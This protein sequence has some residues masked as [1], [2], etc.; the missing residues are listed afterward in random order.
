MVR[1]SLR[2]L[3]Q[4]SCLYRQRELFHQRRRTSNAHPQG[5]AC[6]GPTLFRL[7]KIGP[8]NAE[9]RF[10]RPP[11]SCRLLTQT[12]AVLLAS[13]TAAHAFDETSYPNWR[14]FWEQPGG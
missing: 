3:V 7:A 9:E 5:P 2:K 10:M 6:T 4:R 8:S 1:A 11:G 12:A 13:L 14:G